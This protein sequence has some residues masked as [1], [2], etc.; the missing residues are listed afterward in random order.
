MAEAPHL[1]S[2]MSYY[3]EQGVLARRERDLDS[4]AD[5]I[6]QAVATRHAA[7]QAEPPTDPKAAPP[8]TPGDIPWDFQTLLNNR[9]VDVWMHEQDIRRAI[10]RPGGYDGPAAAHVLA[11]V[12]TGAADGRRQ[13]GL[14][15]AG[16]DRPRRRPRGRARLDGTGR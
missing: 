7:L 15:A 13:A 16:D 5:E 8:K 9:P 4:V 12:R 6:E 2:L 1:K 10:G 3:T 11:R 14:A